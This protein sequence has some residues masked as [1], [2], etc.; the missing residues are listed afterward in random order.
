M[1]RIVVCVRVVVIYLDIVEEQVP[2]HVLSSEAT[3]PRV[4]GRCPEVHLERL[5]VMNVLNSS[6]TDRCMSQLTAIYT[7]TNVL[8]RPLESIR[9]PLIFRIKVIGV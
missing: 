9:V 6:I 4:E 2:G 3:T 8:R 7:P 1:E 5:S